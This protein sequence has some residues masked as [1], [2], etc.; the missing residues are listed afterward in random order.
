MVTTTPS[1]SLRCD[2]ESVDLPRY[3]NAVSDESPRLVDFHS[4]A[5]TSGSSPTSPPL[6][7]LHHFRSSP[8]GH[9]LPL[10][11]PPYRKGYF[12]A[13]LLWKNCEWRRVANLSVGVVSAR[14][15]CDHGALHCSATTTAITTIWATSG[16]RNLVDVLGTF[17]RMSAVEKWRPGLTVSFQPPPSDVPFACGE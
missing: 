5:S 10:L 2:E 9:C 3:S 15:C 7:L 4:P 6:R 1:V 11:S 8:I 13:S 12:R 16:Q 14:P 17:K